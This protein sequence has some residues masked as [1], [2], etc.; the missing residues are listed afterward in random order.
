MNLADQIRAEGDTAARPGQMER[1]HDLAWKV[2]A[3]ERLVKELS[4][5]T[6]IERLRAEAWDEGW[7]A[8]WTPMSLHH[9][10][11]GPNPYR[12]NE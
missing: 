12:S 7:E 11:Q 6:G 1:L 3:L 5:V 4:T 9:K 2:E 8:A 10:D